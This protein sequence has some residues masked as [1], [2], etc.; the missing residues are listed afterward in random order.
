MR[1]V[2]IDRFGPA[3]E[4][5]LVEDASSPTPGPGD[6]LV[7]VLAAGVNPVD[8]KMRDGSNRLVQGVTPDQF[9]IVLGRECCGV[10]LAD[11]QDLP[12][13]TRVF[14]M[15]GEGFGGCYA[16]EALLPA[17]GIVIAPDG[18]A[19]EVLGGAALAWYTALSAVDDLAHVGPDDIVLIHGAGG[20]VG[21]LMVQRCLAAGAEVWASAS[22]KHQERLASLGT[23]VVDYTTTDVFAAVPR[24]TV[25]LDGVWFGTFGPSMNHLQPGG[26]MVALPTLAD[27]TEARARGIE[28][29]I[30]SAAP[31]RDRL[32]ELANGLADGSISIEVSEVLPLADAARAHELLDAGH[33]AGKIVLVP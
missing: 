25:V 6:A 12:A 9:P 19:D 29:G 17:D 3:S 26:R 20:G 7:R 28:A 13:G 27:L 11:T 15:V 10:L 31:D 14:G 32:Q 18:V 23:H 33:V 30:P 16:E 1:Q 5:H 2:Q 24:P 4:L 21:Q 8:R 22:T